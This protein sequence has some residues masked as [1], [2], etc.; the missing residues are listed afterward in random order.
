MTDEANSEATLKT[1]QIFQSKFFYN[2]Q[3][4]VSDTQEQILTTEGVD[5]ANENG[6]P[7]KLEDNTHIFSNNQAEKPY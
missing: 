3:L 6:A 1:N 4:D 7:I 5:D 2:S